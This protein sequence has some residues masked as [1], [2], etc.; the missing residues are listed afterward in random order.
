M[1]PVIFYLLSAH[2][3]FGDDSRFL[4]M[5]K[6]VEEHETYHG[7]DGKRNL[8]HDFNVTTIFCLSCFGNLLEA[9]IRRLAAL[10][11]PVCSAM[12]RC[13]QGRP[14][15]TMDLYLYKWLLCD[16]VMADR[17]EQVAKKPYVAECIRTVS[18]S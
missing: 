12:R 2:H 11:I 7:C 9:R 1:E 10:S 15:C 6:H 8:N 13:Y 16:D 3:S 5:I 18:V 14:Q 4:I 17:D